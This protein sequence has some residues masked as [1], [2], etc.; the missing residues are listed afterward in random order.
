MF[1]LF[2]A[3][4]ECFAKYDAF[5]S[6]IFDYACFRREAYCY[7]RDSK[8][9]KNC[10]H[11]KHFRKWL[12]GGCISF[13][14]P[15]GSAPGYELPIPLKESGIFQSLASL[16]LFC[17]TKR[18]SQKGRPVAQCPSSLDYA[19]GCLQFEVTV[20]LSL[21]KLNKHLSSEDKPSCQAAGVMLT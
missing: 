17:F 11:R 10:I 6:H 9:R 7:R 5:C 18:Q 8:L 4:S 16:V 19:P 2:D 12:V 20:T 15:P 21:V 14:L 13:I 3:N 1:K